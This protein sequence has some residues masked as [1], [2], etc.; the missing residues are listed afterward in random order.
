MNFLTLTADDGATGKI[1]SQG[2]HLCSWIPAGG[3]EQLFMS[4]STAW[5]AGTA[6]RGGV[7]VI[8]PQ[9]A[10][11]GSL[12]KHGFARTA[13]WQLA[14]HGISSSGAAQAVYQLRE[15]IAR[16]TIW[17]YVF[18]AELTIRLAANHLHISLEITNTGDTAFSFTSALHTYLAVDDIRQV[19]L[20]GLQGRHYRDSLQNGADALENAPFLQFDG[21]IDRIYGAVPSLL[22]VQQPHQQLEIRQHGFKDA[23]V[24]NPGATGAVKLADLEPGGEQKM[25]CVEAASILHPIRLAPGESWNGSQILSVTLT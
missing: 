19:Q 18:L 17:P 12:P 11:M 16:L 7:P 8:F 20:H 24:W 21:E 13:E 9:F 22:R 14:A 25:L 2:A 4:K 15:N 10:G 3:A 1:C 23:V 5:Q 6:I